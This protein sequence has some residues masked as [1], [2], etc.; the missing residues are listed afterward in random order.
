MWF[1][2]LWYLIRKSFAIPIGVDIENEEVIF[3]YLTSDLG[4]TKHRIIIKFNQI[5][6]ISDYS[7][8]AIDFPALRIYLHQ[9]QMLN[10]RKRRM[11]SKNDDFLALVDDMNSL[12]KEYNTKKHDKEQNVEQTK[13]V[14]GD[15]TY[16]TDTTLAVFGATFFAIIGLVHAINKEFRIGLFIVPLFLLFFAISS[17][18]IQRN[19]DK[20]RNR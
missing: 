12:V 1:L 19:R 4:V 2:I 3:N 14:F 9:G 17:Y 15:D 16:K 8:D 6:R 11:Y 20:K 10:L 7:P 18:I 13:I 5:S